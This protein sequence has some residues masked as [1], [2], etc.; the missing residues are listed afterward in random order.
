[1]SFNFKEKLAEKL[2]AH[3]KKQMITADQV[4]MY[5][6]NIEHEDILYTQRKDKEYTIITIEGKFENPLLVCSH[7]QINARMTRH[8]NT[9]TFKF[10]LD[11]MPVID[12][13]ESRVII[14]DG[15]R[16]FNL[17]TGNT[18]KKANY[19]NIVSVWY[20]DSHI[21]YFRNTASKYG[22]L[23][24]QKKTREYFESPE[25]AKLQREL[26]RKYKQADVSGV[27]IYEKNIM[28]FEESG[29]RL[30][31]QIYDR[32]NVYYV[33][34]K[35]A[36][37]YNEIKEKYGDKIVSPDEAKFIELLHTSEYYIGTELPI[38]LISLRSPY[39]S[40][41]KEIM[42]SN[43]HKFIFLQHGV[44]YA[45]SVEGSVRSVFRKNGLYKPYKV[46]VS[47]ELEAQHLIEFGKYEAD[48]LWK[49]GLATFDNKRIDQNASKTT[50]MLTWRPWDEL[51]A[52]EE[53]TYYQALIKIFNNI[54]N[55]KNLQFILHPKVKDEINSSSP[56]Y[57]YICHQ[58]VDQA[59]NSTKVLISD[60]SSIVF[61]AFYRGSNVIFW[62]V[63]KDECLEKYN[64]KLLLNESNIFGDI[65]YDSEYI[66]ETLEKNSQ[67]QTN[68]YYVNK[69]RNIV[70]FRDDQNTSRIIKN[71]ENY[72]I[73]PPK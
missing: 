70:E 33:L 35:D 12:G 36:D 4:A 8:E 15:N 45:L 59:L 5:I 68:M 41:R 54:S 64:N 24:F 32:D 29:A 55:K 50:V 62:W 28:R 48:D 46:I 6:D 27:L 67:V 25:Y 63:E 19:N 21:Y 10:K 11:D 13:I 31:E 42:R 58:P 2:H 16:V 71:L 69:Y 30:F 52:I 20:T 34:S 18:K 47:S 66:D 57:E 39:K 37:C 26:H 3:K 17:S 43:K 56:L 14:I 61:D 38:H 22:R 1:M 9:F 53:T 40:L 7:G 65:V 73:I 72:G 60:Y 49:T 23:V 44:T 51:K